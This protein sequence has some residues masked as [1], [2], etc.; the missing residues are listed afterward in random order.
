M[1]EKSAKKLLQ[2][3]GANMDVVHCMKIET[4][5]PES[6]FNLKF[7]IL[8]VWICDSITIEKQNQ[9]MKGLPNSL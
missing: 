7:L 1:N 5:V 9:K 2:P 8:N 4:V 6:S 3:P